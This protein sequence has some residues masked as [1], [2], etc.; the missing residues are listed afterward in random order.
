MPSLAI[1]MVLLSSS[2]ICVVLKIILP[3]IST[4]G[5]A[6]M[7][8][9]DRMFRNDYHKSKTRKHDVRTHTAM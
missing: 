1:R 9:K 7:G 3:S 2:E 6:L 4:I 8:M 5:R